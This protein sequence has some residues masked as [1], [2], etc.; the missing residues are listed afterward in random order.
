MLLPAEIRQL[1]VDP[2][3]ELK[4]ALLPAVEAA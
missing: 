1:V 4:R 3:Q 2:A